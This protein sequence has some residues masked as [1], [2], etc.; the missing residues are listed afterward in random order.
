MSYIVV[1]I[2]EWEAERARVKPM[3][4]VREAAIG[5]NPYVQVTMTDGTSRP[6]LRIR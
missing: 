5:G 4:E 6:D 1:M 3:F 2:E